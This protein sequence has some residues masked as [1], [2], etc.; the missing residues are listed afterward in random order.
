M[1]AIQKSLLWTRPNEKNIQDFHGDDLMLHLNCHQ[2][3]TIQSFDAVHQTASATVDIQKVNYVPNTQTGLDSQAL[4]AYPPLTDCPVKFNCGLNGG[5][6]IPVKQGDKCLIHFNDRDFDAW[7]AGAIN[8]EPNTARLHDFSDAVI[9]IGPNPE[10]APLPNFSTQ[11][12]MLRSG[13]GNSFFGLDISNGK[14]TIQNSQGNLATL[15]QQL[16]SAIQSLTVTCPS[17]GGPS[18]L[19]INSATFA[20]IGT[21]LGKVLE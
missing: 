6:T 1:T 17:G 8:Q 21:N 10:V 7:A 13:D 3:G 12:V 19:P 4:L 18:S 11:Y 5:V 15:L 16:I 2:I 9:E 14:L 20:T